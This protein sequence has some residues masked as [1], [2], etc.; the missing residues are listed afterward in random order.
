MKI[1][2]IL[3]ITVL[4]S[5]IANDAHAEM[6]GDEM[7]AAGA[8]AYDSG[9]YTEARKNW[10]D[11]AMFGHVDAMSSLADLMMR[12]QGG[13]TDIAT[14]I[15]WCRRAARRGDATASLTLG[16]LALGSPDDPIR[17]HMAAFVW[18]SIS[19]RQG[20]IWARN[21]ASVL[22]GKLS[23]S[24]RAMADRLINKKALPKF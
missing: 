4:I 19:A 7:F 6:P 23:E 22:M 15:I 10:Y 2:V 13:P 8:Q 5:A 11:A 16:E 1:S 9:N 18:F 3:L 14:A 12:G 20:N 24:E 21:E 17:D